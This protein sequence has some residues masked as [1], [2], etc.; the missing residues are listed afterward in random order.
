MS[1]ISRDSEFSKQGAKNEDD[2]LEMIDHSF[3]DLIEE[4]TFPWFLEKWI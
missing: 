1:C 4:E 3:Y 2:V